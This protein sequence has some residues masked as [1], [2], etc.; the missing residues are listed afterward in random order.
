MKRS[1]CLGLMAMAAGILLLTACR[2]ASPVAEPSG[3]PTSE[4][5]ETAHTDTLLMDFTSG[6]HVEDVRPVE[7][8]QSIPMS[9]LCDTLEQIT[10]IQFDFTVQTGETG[11][12]VTWQD[13]SALVQ[14]ETPQDEQQD[15]VFYDDD[16]LR[17]FMLDTVWRNLTEEFGA[18]Q[19]VY[20]GPDG[21]ALRLE[22]PWPLGDFDLSQPY[23][24][25][26]WY[27]A[28]YTSADWDS[29]GVPEN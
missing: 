13:T 16:L 5:G 29:D 1:V 2:E 23:Q 14:G 17:W 24:G 27:C 21:T 28:Q 7:L 26:T 4:T 25:S 6:S 19:V 9:E 11:C 8:E 20:A 3:N 12:V 22:E 10:G 18:A 15:Y